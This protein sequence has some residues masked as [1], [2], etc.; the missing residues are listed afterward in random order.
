MKEN[1][2]NWELSHVPTVVTQVGVKRNSVSIPIYPHQWFR[3]SCCIKTFKKFL[4]SQKYHLIPKSVYTPKLYKIINR[5]INSAEDLASVRIKNDQNQSADH[6]KWKSDI[7][8][9]IINAYK[10]L[11]INKI[12]PKF[13]RHTNFK[14]RKCKMIFIKLPKILVWDLFQ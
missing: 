10:F 13:Q 9:T 2:S 11:G 4:P 8:L 3:K 1:C 12:R 14:G 7:M 5:F 6:F